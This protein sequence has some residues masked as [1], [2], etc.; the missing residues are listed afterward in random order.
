MDW[1]PL[2][3][4]TTWF[5]QAALNSFS[6]NPLE[7]EAGNARGQGLVRLLRLGFMTRNN[8][9][10]HLVW[11]RNHVTRSAPTAPPV[12]AEPDSLD[13]SHPPG[14]FPANSAAI[15]SAG[16]QAQS[17]T[18]FD[19]PPASHSNPP[20][21]SPRPS[22]NEAR[23]TTHPR[24]TNR[25]VVQ[26]RGMS[27]LAPD[28]S[29][30]QPESVAKRQPLS[31]PA[32]ATGT[33]PIGPLQ[34]AYSASLARQSSSS[35]IRPK[36]KSPSPTSRRD[37]GKLGIADF[38]D[39]VLS[40][41]VDLTDADN[42]DGSSSVLGFGEDK[43][44]W[45][46]DFAERPEPAS[47][48]DR[49]RKIEHVSGGGRG[50][51]QELDGDDDEFPDIDDLIHPSSVLKLVAKQRSIPPSGSPE[52]ESPCVQRIPGSRSPADDLGEMEVDLAGSDAGAIP[53][54][55]SMT[56]SPSVQGPDLSSTM[57]NR[58]R[59]SSSSAGPSD[60]ETTKLALV[61]S[62]RTRRPDIV[63]DSEDEFVAPPTHRS[64]VNLGTS[65]DLGANQAAI[66]TQETDVEPS[67]PDVSTPLRAP[68]LSGSVSL[69]LSHRKHES[70]LSSDTA[71][72]APSD[73]ALPSRESRHKRNSQ[74]SLDSELERNRHILELLLS[75]PSVLQN[76]L[77]SINDQLRRNQDEFSRCLR[78]N[79]PME[80]RDRVRN[81]RPLLI[82]KQNALNVMMAEYKS[83]KELSSK[84]EALL[85]DIGIAYAKG[86]DTTGD[87]ARLDRLSERV[88]AKETVLI[89]SFVTAGLDD[90]DFLKDPNDSIAG[91]DS[92]N[93]VVSAT[94]SSRKFGLRS[95][96]SETSAIP[97]YN[98][99]VVLQTQLSQSRTR[100]ASGSN[101]A[102]MLLPPTPSLSRS[103]S[104]ATQCKVR[105]A[106]IEIQDDGTFDDDGVEAVSRSVKSSA[107]LPQKPPALRT[108]TPAK[109][110]AAP[111][112]DDFEDLSDEE[113]MLA[114]ADSLEQRRP[115]IRPGPESH[116][117]RS[118]LSE[119]SGNVG[120]P[121]RRRPA[122]RN[123]PPLRPRASFPPEQMRYP[124]SADVRRALK[125]R[126]RMTSFRPNQLE[127]I[128]ATLAG[129]DAFVL[130]PTGGG[131]SLCYQLPAV[132]KSGKTRGITI[133][134]S[135]LLSLMHDQVAHLDRLSIRAA[136]FNGEMASNVRNHVL[137]LFEDA[138]PEHTVQL[139]Y[140][141]PEMV[142]NSNAFR[143]G[144]QSLYQK[145]KLARIVIDEAHCVSHW[146]HD[147]RPDYKALGSL[148]R[149]FPGV[150]VMALTAT[151][152]R[153]VI[154]DIKHNLDMEDCEIFSQSFNRP[155]LYYE[156]RAKEGSFLK[157]MGELIATKHAGQSGIIYTLSRK[158]AESIAG[159]LVANHKIKAQHYHAQMDPSAKVDVQQRWQSGDIQVVVATIAF[160]MGIDKPDVRFVI[161]QYMPKSLEGYYQ[162]TGRAGRDGQHSD[163]YLYFSYGDIPALRRMINEDKDK[164]QEQKER[165]HAMLN[166]MVSYCESRHVCRRVQIL[167][168]FGEK[169]DAAQCNSQCD[170]CK[171]GRRSGTAELQDFTDCALALLKAVRHMKQ[172]TL[173]K[174]VEVVI[175]KHPSKNKDVDGQGL[176]KGMKNYEVQRVLIALH[177][178]GALNDE[179]VVS[180]GNSI[181][182]THFRLGRL[183]GDYFRGK[184]QLKL[185]VP[186]ADSTFGQ[187]RTNGLVAPVRDGPSDL[188]SRAQS[189]RPPPSTNISSPIRAATK[190]RN[191]KS[192]VKTFGDKENEEIDAEAGW[193]LYGN[194]YK[195]D[196]FVVSDQEDDDYYYD[197]KEQQ[198][199]EE[200]EEEEE[201]EAFEPVPPHRSLL[202]RQ[203]QQTLDELGPPIS[204]DAHL[205]GAGLNEIHLDIVQ[206]FVEKANVV[207]ENLR[208]KH[209][210]RRPL[211]TEQQY[212]E[213]AMRWTTS[214]AKMYTIRGVDKSKV[215]LYGAKFASLVLQFYKQYQ[216]MMGGTVPSHSAAEIV[217]KQKKQEV[218]VLIS[219]DEDCSTGH[220]RGRRIGV[221]DRGRHQD[222]D[223]EDD[224]DEGSLESSR[225][226]ANGAARATSLTRPEPSS[227]LKW[228]KE[229]KEMSA[230]AKKPYQ[231]S[232]SNSGSNWGGRKKTYN[233]KN[234]GMRGATPRGAGGASFQRAGTVGVSKHRGS[235][236]KQTG[237]GAFSAGSGV[238]SGRSKSLAPKAA[239]KKSGSG[240]GISTMPY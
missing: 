150:P 71:E 156:V 92:P 11:L 88:K 136:P 15:P 218:V 172:A 200:E 82:Q 173:A 62:K 117:A 108:K 4:Q 70:G 118:V 214:V 107:L 132:V 30:R 100:V 23:H 47:N 182:V 213:M 149:E 160:G 114:A 125:D 103:H 24:V 206:A 129:K 162:E 222:H 201:E 48:R 19:S 197:D 158:S 99:Q 152:T 122:A 113:E 42:H 229:L 232:Q 185:E 223:D 203:R 3:N 61:R 111:V 186:N 194:G 217:P 80:V 131:K 224:E 53:H 234:R 208:N 184:R 75:R 67:S 133:V 46:E 6:R 211:F 38:D 64:A 135:P 36:K 169:F 12:P 179:Q 37:A 221:N 17:S 52:P 190:K 16:S 127:A 139:L 180:Q 240:S 86:L 225:Y 205:D 153:N 84:R 68:P 87:E 207:E 144:L 81:A 210:L 58:K 8:L 226:F 216:E 120:A 33:T 43:R 22:A 128:N 178:E 25:L 66:L 115:T 49:K 41:A 40:D 140:V 105:P 110:A 20:A 28:A 155:N 151:A 1:S 198:Q 212:R 79:A 137:Q 166:R 18:A 121:L 119:S 7:L 191:A 189:R 90:L 45:R 219:D 183:A 9:G 13:P 202:P 102:D 124:W 57:S 239:S 63:L 138:N 72:D 215:D 34:R 44:L 76:T 171:D 123:V 161:H 32:S 54:S 97:E 112:R 237:R 195:R 188:S 69:V 147:F 78:E 159:M 98:S 109:P 187:P 233:P 73:E 55:S 26:E 142:V 21:I 94:Q 167:E 91:P 10:D 220:G 176:C 196:G 51:K 85:A 146:G 209:G 157:L 168:Y 39:D 181:P 96:S 227:V 163:C 95:L 193:E 143:R 126:F 2:F 165:Q 60:D 56:L 154:A 175:G 29:S 238:R 74:G 35:S 192:A 235:T 106:V 170:N 27:G 50:I 148:R 134:I 145:K 83:F 93:P 31:A 164:P 130:M 65:S 204:R 174:A 231:A 199:Q 177:A 89:S 5:I 101:T 228:H 116:R 230:S 77:Q 236:A 59:K 141:T 104:A 14:S